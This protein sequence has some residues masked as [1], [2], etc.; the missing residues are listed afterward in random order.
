M[1][2]VSIMEVYQTVVDLCTWL[3]SNDFWR[4]W[5]EKA[6]LTWLKYEIEYDLYK[7]AQKLKK[8]KF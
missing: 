1:M 3:K 2:N 5:L 6:W 4:L 8:T 7:I